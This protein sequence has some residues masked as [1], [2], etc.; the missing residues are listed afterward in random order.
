MNN[1]IRIL[2]SLLTLVLI[3]SSCSKDDDITNPLNNN[4]TPFQ[5]LYDQG[6]DRYLSSFSPTS[7][8]S[9]GSVIEYFFD[10]PDG[11]ICFTGNDFSM[12]TR[13]GSTNDL[14]IFLQGGGFCNP[15]SCEAVETGIPFIPFG[16]LDPNDATNPVNDYNTGYIPYCDGSAMIGDRDVDS[17]GDGIDDRFF[18]GVQNLSASLDVIKNKYPSPEKIVLAGNSAGGFAVHHALPLVRKLYP[19]I[20]I[21]IINDSGVGIINPG[22]WQMNI[23]YWNGGSFYPTNC[24]DCIGA[25]GNLTGYHLYQLEQDENI[26]MAYISSKQDETFA[27][28]TQGGGPAFETQL[29]EASN[30]LND[31]YPNRFNSLIA[32][33]DEH[34]FILSDYIFQVGSTNVRSWIDDMVNENNWTS[35]TE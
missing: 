15:N 32:N 1:L 2:I 18:R 26:L 28:L 34:T 29:L 10:I 16:M 8:N 27:L 30:E 22:G 19:D 9:T 4:S 12:F 20:K 17:D 35:V 3:V 25:D 6:V 23:D 14:L 33:G 5:E 13:D 21:Y 31:A 11:P 24:N 7:S